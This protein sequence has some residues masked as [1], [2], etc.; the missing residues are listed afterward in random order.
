MAQTGTTDVVREEEGGR[1]LAT[2]P[3]VKKAAQTSNLTQDE[4]DTALAWLLSDESDAATVTKNLR[5]NV[6][7]SKNPQWIPW[8]IRSTDR[9]VLRS[10]QRSTGGSRAARRA[11]TAEIDPGEANLKIVAH[12][13]VNPDLAAAAKAK[14]IQDAPDPLYAPMQVLRWRF[15]DKPGL[16][17]Q[18][19]GFVMEA[20]GY[21]DE[22]VQE[23]EEVVAAGN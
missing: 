8:T 1:E 4:Q 13:T 11:G 18:I 22:D 16:I 17:D 6:G 12:A 3:E 2:P 10:L 14:G 15:R 19:A 23:S 7:S 5:L 21:D 20:S 9:E